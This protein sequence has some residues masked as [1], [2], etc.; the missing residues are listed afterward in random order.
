MIAKG[1]CCESLMRRGERALKLGEC[2]G[3]GA[4]VA[5]AISPVE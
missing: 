2:V 4:R 5:A 3:S 1:G